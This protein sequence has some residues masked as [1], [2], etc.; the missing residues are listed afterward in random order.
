MKIVNKFENIVWM[1]SVAEIKTFQPQIGY[2][3][4]EEE[5][6]ST[7]QVNDILSW[8]TTS[9]WSKRRLDLEPIL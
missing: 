8:I 4:I 9:L 7:S 3:K 6:E 5:G 1:C 2:L